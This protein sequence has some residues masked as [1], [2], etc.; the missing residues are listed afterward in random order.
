M[1]ATK[2]KNTRSDSLNSKLFILLLGCLLAGFVWIDQFQV[3]KNSNI[4]V[5]EVHAIKNYYMNKQGVTTTTTVT[6]RNL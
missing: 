3:I 5:S 6:S 2:P 4:F 1:R